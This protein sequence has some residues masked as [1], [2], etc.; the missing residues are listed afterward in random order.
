MPSLMAEWNL[1]AMQAGA[2]GSCALVGMMVGALF[3]GSLSDRI[4]RRKTIMACAVPLHCRAGH[5]WRH[6]QC[7][8]VDERIRARQVAQHFG[9]NHVQRV[10]ARRHAVGRAGDAVHPAVG[11]AGGVLR[12]GDSAVA[13]AVADTPVAR[14][15]GLFIAQ[16]ANRTGQGFAGAGNAGVFAG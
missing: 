11:V 1:S 2:L 9:G 5:R 7:G 13:V 16:W 10:F 8:R 12:S 4:G 15:H 14:V 6:A 3:F